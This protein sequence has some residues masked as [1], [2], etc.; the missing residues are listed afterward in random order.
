MAEESERRCTTS[1]R[2]R[3]SGAD[4]PVMTKA[5]EVTEVEESRE[6]IFTIAGI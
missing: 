3:I 5:T 2:K 1:E 4:P 6:R